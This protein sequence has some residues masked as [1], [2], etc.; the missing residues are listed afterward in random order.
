[1]KKLFII[2]VCLIA[3]MSCLGDI[4][5]AHAYDER[6]EIVL[7][8]CINNYLTF[9]DYNLPDMVLE[10][11]PQLKKM[12][13]DVYYK[14]NDGVSGLTE[15]L[16]NAVNNLDTTG[17]FDWKF[18]DEVQIYERA[19]EN[20]LF[21]ASKDVEKSEDRVNEFAD[22]CGDAVDAFD[23]FNTLAQNT[24]IM[25]RHNNDIAYV[26]QEFPFES[27]KKG[28]SKAG[29]IADSAEKL[30]SLAYVLFQDLAMNLSII[31]E[32]EEA[33]IFST[34]DERR[35]NIISEAADRISDK[36]SSQ[37]CDRVKEWFEETVIEEGASLLTSEATSVMPVVKVA[38]EI[39]KLT[40]N[41]FEFERK[42]NEYVDAEFAEIFREDASG[43]YLHLRSLASMGELENA[44]QR[45]ESNYY[46]NKYLT[47]ASYEAAQKI[48]G[49]AFGRKEKQQED[50][51]KDLLQK[52]LD[53]LYAFE[54]SYYSL[55]YRLKSG[56]V[57]N[58]PDPFE[59]PLDTKAENSIGNTSGNIANGGIAAESNG[60]IYYRSND[61]GSI[62]KMKNDGSEETKLNSDN[63]RYINVVGEWVYYIKATDEREGHY[64]DIFRMRTDGSSRTL[65]AEGDYSLL[66]V[67]GGYLYCIVRTDSSQNEWY[68]GGDTVRMDLDGGSRQV[69]SELSYACVSGNSIIYK[70]TV[71][72]HDEPDWQEATIEESLLLSNLDGTGEKEIATA[73]WNNGCFG[74]ESAH[75]ADEKVYYGELN[76]L[77]GDGNIYE[78]DIATGET[79]CMKELSSK[80]HSAI[81]YDDE[82]LYYSQTDYCY[83][84]KYVNAI[85]KVSLADLAP[86]V[87]VHDDDESI[88][89]ENICIAGDWMFYE[90]NQIMLGGDID[91][92]PTSVEKVLLY[93]NMGAL[94][95]VE[96]DE[97]LENIKSDTLIVTL[98]ELA[99]NGSDTE[100]YGMYE[101]EDGFVLTCG[102]EDICMLTYDEYRELAEG[103]VVDTEVGEVIESSETMGYCPDDAFSFANVDG[104]DDGY[105][106][107]KI[108]EPKQKVPIYSV[109]LIDPISYKTGE[110]K[111]FFVAN[112][113]VVKIIDYDPWFK[114]IS[115]EEFITT[116]NFAYDFRYYA[117]IEDNSI[118]ELEE[119]YEP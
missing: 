65:V 47:I 83:E 33:L 51:M 44:P 61:N 54:N 105:Y 9:D 77:A 118:I 11:Y 50:M 115:F 103:K 40:A 67:Q 59:K 110:S 56:E 32:L 113:T 84:P 24:I 30:S 86:I 42:V 112:D 43:Y 17:D 87:I 52:S 63:C 95:I 10:R 98:R 2:V 75:I 109:W 41:I 49:D 45:L 16:L 71:D 74:W 12:R 60:W 96:D 7:D 20:V 62:Y 19:F 69:I 38:D 13:N 6:E 94:S 1:M 102:I 85:F 55:E 46:L 3:L 58:D 92:R 119:M 114:E 68:D 48:A 25:N 4:K 36:Y 22:N 14:L 23:T 111:E 82:Y 91:V 26:L 97:E 93:A 100:L 80:M 116:E 37:V 34:G 57:V 90:I 117:K 101:L 81:N 35:K 88:I 79:S 78:Y 39:I 53:I 76:G 106:I 5:T 21:A 70:R 99:A 64:G 8:Y 72:H 108:P 27:V 29:D 28:L 15:R 73:G 89:F 66:T 107:M 104:E 18:E 31:E